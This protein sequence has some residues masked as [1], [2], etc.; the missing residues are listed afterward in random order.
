M[1]YVEKLKDPRWQ[2]KRL[3][4]F[5]RD[6]WACKGCGNTKNTLHVHHL[7]YF[8]NKEPWEI[9]NGFLITLCENCHNSGGSCPT[10]QDFKSCKECPNFVLNEDGDCE[11]SG[12]K[13]EIGILLNTIWQMGY[14][15]EEDL[16]NISESIFNAG[17]RPC[18]APLE[19]KFEA[20]K[21]IPK[22]KE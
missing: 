12:D 17:K 7:F 8:K 11:G 15:F 22:P 3:E 1:D 13:T 4:I 19:C 16:V 20:K 18:G 2:K 6:G 5:E 14:D 9:H 10:M 21:W